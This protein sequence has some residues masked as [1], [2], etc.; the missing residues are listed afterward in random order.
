MNLLGWCAL[1]VPAGTAAEGLPF[2]VTLIGPANHDAVLSGV[3]QAWM[4]APDASPPTAAQATLRGPATE[5]TLTLAVVGAHLRGLPLNGQLVERGARFLQA[6]TTAPL[7]RLFALPGTTPLKPGM[8]RVP[9]GGVAIALELWALPMSQVGSFLALI[10]AP[11]GLG[12]LT[13]ADGS[14]VHGFLC[15]SHALTGAQDISY[16]GGWRAFLAA[17]ADTPAAAAPAPN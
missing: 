3:G 11:L 15:E 12:S 7:Y 13:L 1:A 8:V 5:P 17:R 9:D 2:G 14:S 6:T 16:H 10:P 4:Q